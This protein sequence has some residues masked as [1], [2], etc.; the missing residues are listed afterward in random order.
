MDVP[1]IILSASSLA[2]GVTGTSPQIGFYETR[3]WSSNILFNPVN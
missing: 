3:K 2:G 1:D